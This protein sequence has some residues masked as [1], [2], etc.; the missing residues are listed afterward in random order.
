MLVSGKGQ[1]TA[2]SRGTL[3]VVPA[4]TCAGQTDN[5]KSPRIVEMPQAKVDRVLLGSSCQFIDEALQREDVRVSPERAQRRHSQR[6]CRDKM[7]N[8]PRLGKVVEWNSIAIATSFRLRQ[9]LRRRRHEW[10]LQ[11]RGREQVARFAGTRGVGVAPDLE[12]PIDN[13]TRGIEAGTH[14]VDHWRTER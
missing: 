3:I 11:M 12:L 1:A 9:R 4:E 8:D 10:L 13:G 7:M 5:R 14:R 2:A 6:H